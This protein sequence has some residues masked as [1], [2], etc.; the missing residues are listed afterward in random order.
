MNKY[1]IIIPVYNCEEY[2]RLCVNSILNQSYKDFEIILVDDGS[3]DGSLSVCKDLSRKHSNIKVFHKENGGAASARNVGIEKA[4]G[5]YLMF[6]DGDDILD[7][8]SLYSIDDIFT[9]DFQLCL[10]GMSFDYYHEDSLVRNEVLSCVNKGSYN[11]EKLLK[12]FKVFFDDNALSSACN[13]VFVADVIAKNNLRFVEGMTLYEDFDFVLKYLNCIDNIVCIDKPFYHYRHIIIKQHLNARVRDLKKLSSNQ[14]LLF[15]TVSLFRNEHD[16]ITV[17]ANLYIQ[18]LIQHLMN[19]KITVKYLKSNL[20]KYFS[21]DLFRKMI[22]YGAVLNKNERKLLSWV[23]KSKFASIW[24]KY[25]VMKIKLK[26][27][28]LIK[29]LITRR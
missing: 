12:N 15:Q 9:D 18:L 25:R 17:V 11:K 5:K 1:S 20:P 10:F 19:R 3:T 16:V 28:R 27:R 8:N 2:L 26:T 23:D 4:H 14:H 7:E 21:D 6:I 29:K 13:K 22:E 24:A